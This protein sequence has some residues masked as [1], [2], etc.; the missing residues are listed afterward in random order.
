[1]GNQI[2]KV[3]KTVL[4]NSVPVINNPN[5][6]NWFVDNQTNSYINDQKN[7]SQNLL[8]ELEKSFANYNKLLRLEFITK[9]WIL[10]YKGLTFNVFTSKRKGTYVEICG[11]SYEDIQSGKNEKEIINFLGELHKLVNLC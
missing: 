6:L 8:E 1:M 11:H 2:N 4:E 9:V 7:L 5:I 10:E 3:K